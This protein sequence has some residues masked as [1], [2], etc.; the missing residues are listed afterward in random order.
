[1]SLSNGGSNK[2]IISKNQLTLWKSIIS[3]NQ[4]TLWPRNKF[5]K[6]HRVWRRSPGPTLDQ[7]WTNPAY[8]GSPDG[9]AERSCRAIRLPQ[10]KKEPL[11]D[12]LH[13]VPSGSHFP[14]RS[15]C[16]IWMYGE[17]HQGLWMVGKIGQAE[18]ARRDRGTRSEASL[19]P[20]T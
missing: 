17:P 14:A 3:K 13:V 1:M 12:S 19:V 8:R 4:L 9:F 15:P 5:Y 16:L 20:G 18:R 11:G 7:S 10:T 6:T 2:S